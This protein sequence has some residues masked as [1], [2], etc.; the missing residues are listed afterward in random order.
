MEILCLLLLCLGFLG[1]SP[2][3]LGAA[4]GGPDAYGYTWRDSAEPNGP[5]YQWIDVRQ[6]A[7]ALQ[8]LGLGD[9]NSVGPIN[10]GWDFH[11]Y[12]LDF[13]ELTFGSNGWIGLGEEGDVN[14]ISHCFP[15]LPSSGGA[16]DNFIA[17]LLSDLNF[18]SNN[19]NFPN[20]GT[21]FI[22]SNL[23]DSVILQYQDV[24]FWR[25]DTINWTGANT[26]Q[27]IL[28]GRDSSITFQYQNLD[29]SAF[30]QITTC[31]TDLVVGLENITGA[32]GLELLRESFPDNNY[33]IKF[34]YPSPVLQPAADATPLWNGDANNSGRFY[35]RDDTI[36]FSTSV[37]NIGN[38]TFSQPVRVNVS[39]RNLL[40]QPLWEDSTD[41]ATLNP[42]AMPV[43][44]YTPD[45]VLK[46]P[47]EY[48]FA[49]TTSS[50]EDPNPKNNANYAEVNVADCN[51]DTF[52]LSYASGDPPTSFFVWGGGGPLDGVGTYIVPPAYPLTIEAVDCWI[53]GDND[54]NNGSPGGYYIKVYDDNGVPGTLL[55]SIFV[56]RNVVQEGAW[57][58]TVLNNPI[59][60]NSGGIL[61]A[62]TQENDSIFL[63]AEN[64]GPVSRWAFEILGGTW[65]DY[66]F[67]EE[68]DFLI[69]VAG[70]GCN[71]HVPV[72]VSEA[73]SALGLTV[74]PN[75]ASDHLQISLDLPNSGPVEWT[76]YDAY[77][78]AHIE[79][80]QLAGLG[81]QFF[82][83][84]LPRLSAGIYF[85]QAR[86]NGRQE[87]R[88]F[89]L[90][91]Q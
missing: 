71:V 81:S 26:F 61:I 6:R 27:V 41:L 30:N 67:A 15:G 28:S 58:R 3:Q 13:D 18:A 53:I 17:P 55:D 10:F 44:D 47:G 24:P 87:T 23:Q 50:S 54:P 59:T 46:S 34:Y 22:W 62:W 66:R 40:Q 32:D 37:S 86:F 51:S 52:Q 82:R 29:P 25:D 7:G 75:P 76:I 1:G 91:P 16:A 68:E 12:W 35:F 57:N 33:A 31:E 9:D 43:L 48:Y 56:P 89:V 88:R 38:G 36:N 84:E 45:Y 21:A 4:S 2:L 78:R 39:L 19:I 65:T 63:G 83:Q 8:L 74:F 42:G 80:R 85:L 20:P 72:S 79:N 90:Q 14:T 69:R 64:V 5:A 77:G 11:Y 60:V 73:Q 70:T 49:T